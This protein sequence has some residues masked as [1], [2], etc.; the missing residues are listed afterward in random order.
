L[1]DVIVAEAVD[2]GD[3]SSCAGLANYAITRTLLV[4]FTKLFPRP[5]YFHYALMDGVLGHVQKEIY[6]RRVASFEDEKCQLNGDV[7][8]F[9]G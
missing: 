4:T 6:R 3:E 2:S 9:E 8:E 5:R 7:K 1:V